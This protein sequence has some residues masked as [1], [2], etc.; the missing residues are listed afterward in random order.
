MAIEPPRLVPDTLSEEFREW[1][2]VTLAPVSCSQ[3]HWCT[4][5]RAAQ[6]SA[7]AMAA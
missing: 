5:R 1:V 6:P 7:A 2:T 3:R 4:I